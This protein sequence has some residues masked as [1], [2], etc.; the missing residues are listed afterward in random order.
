MI[1]KWMKISFIILNL[2]LLSSFDNEI[3]TKSF[4]KCTPTDSKT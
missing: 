3:D 4:L 2:D 1:K